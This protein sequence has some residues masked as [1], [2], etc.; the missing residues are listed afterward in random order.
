MKKGFTLI[1][2]LAVLAILAIIIVISI[3]TILN[4][5]ENAK[6]TARDKNIDMILSSARVYAGDNKIGI[7]TAILLSELC[8]KNYLTCPIEDPI[9]EEVMNGY[10]YS[11]IDVEN[12][13]SIN[14]KYID[15]TPIKLKDTLLSNVVGNVVTGD[16]G[17]SPTNGLYRWTDYY[18]TGIHKYIFRGGITKTNANGLATSDYA[19]DTDTPGT[20]LNNYIKVPW[21]TYGTSETCS[22]ATNN[23]CYRIVSI[24]EDGSIT[25]TRDRS[26][27]T[28]RF[29]YGQNSN[30]TTPNTYGYN[31]LLDNYYTTYESEKRPYSEM[32]TYLYGTGGYESTL[33]S[34]S[35]ILQPLDVCLNKVN[36][37]VGINNTSY[38]SSTAVKDTCNVSG[39]PSTKEVSSVKNRYVRLP[40]LEEYINASFERTCTADFQYQCRSRNYMYSKQTF[41]SFNGYSS[42]PWHV[43]HVPALGSA[44]V[45]DASSSCAVRPTMNLKQN[46]IITGGDGT[47]SNPYVIAN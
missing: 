3:P 28:Q 2:L 46:I 39:K 27:K 42:N 9:T 38:S 6:E 14:Y 47:T 17:A 11:Y 37:Y 40:Y 5:L 7:S 10:I 21:E 41:W 44:G 8:N 36:S 31:D 34:Y 19:T 1:E 29:D 22:D 18:G 45:T 43:R 35:S 33:S 32:Y 4:V 12:N 15:G 30:T 24:N 13:K 26:V 16:P 23:K 25:I 20:D